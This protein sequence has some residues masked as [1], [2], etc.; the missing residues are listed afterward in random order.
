MLQISMT[1]EALEEIQKAQPE[2]KM[3]RDGNP[4]HPNF[5]TGNVLNIDS[6]CKPFVMVSLGKK[7]TRRWVCFL[8]VRSASERLGGP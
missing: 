4:N 7:G 5:T 8:I 3:T 2:G 1:F 6:R